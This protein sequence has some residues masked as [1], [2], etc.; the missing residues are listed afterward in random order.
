MTVH[1]DGCDEDRLTHTC[2]SSVTS[3][4]SVACVTSKSSV[5]CIVHNN[6]MFDSWSSEIPGQSCLLMY[7]DTRGQHGV[8][9]RN[10]AMP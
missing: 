5:T 3:S 6:Q 10:I 2:I 1:W 4:S 9:T 7:A 8:M